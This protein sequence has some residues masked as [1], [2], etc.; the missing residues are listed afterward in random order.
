MVSLF[1]FRL[2]E[3]S[4]SLHIEM[5]IT[6]KKGFTIKEKFRRALKEEILAEGAYR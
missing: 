2:T 1:C 3:G 4:E 5:D 6:P